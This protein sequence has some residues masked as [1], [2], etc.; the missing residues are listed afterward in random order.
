MGFAWAS[1]VLTRGVDP[2]RMSQW[3][4][5][6]GLPAF[7]LVMAS[8]HWQSNL[9]LSAGVFLIG[10]GGGLFGHGTLTASMHLAPPEQ[11][12]LALGAW[13]AVQASAAGLAV[14]LGGVIRDVV[15]ASHGL[16]FGYQMV[17]GIEM[18][19]LLM[20]W[21]SLRPLLDSKSTQGN[22]GTYS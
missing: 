6:I 12:G 18:L 2:Y 9:L 15:G 10:L 1:K 7:V 14:A 21:I 4:V 19:L 17:Y 20:T 8:A 13:G 11:S 3:G 16:N 22:I 5:L